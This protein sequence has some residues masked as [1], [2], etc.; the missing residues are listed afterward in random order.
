MGRILKWLVGALVLCALAAAAAVLSVQQWLRT[1]DF[2]VRMQQ[3]ATQVLGVPL[4]IGKL[5]VDM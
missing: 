3:Q 1:D 2:R 5:S 4:Q